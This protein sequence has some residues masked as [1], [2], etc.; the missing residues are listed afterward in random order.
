MAR[1][2]T[3]DTVHHLV[4]FQQTGNTASF[5]A[6]WADAEAFVDRNA[7]TW[8]RSHV[9]VGADGSVDR[10]AVDDVKQGF[11]IK[12]LELPKKANQSG[13]FD[14]DRFGWEPDRLRGWIYRVV[15]NVAVDYCKQF[16]NLGK[17]TASITFGD[18]ELNDGETVESVL[19]PSPKVDFDAF[20]LRDI[21][22]ECL[23]EL[24]AEQRALCHEFFV[25]GLS[26]R[27]VARGTGVSAPTVCRHWQE[28]A[29]VLR[30]KLL[31]RGVDASWLNH[32]A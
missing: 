14:H 17:K 3:H 10:T 20:E 31:A 18:L 11:V 2:I 27:D 12:I 28:A 21:V 32:A 22:A 29:D 5:E 23:G 7:S 30:A 6:F 13:W 1:S 8:L 15:R 4:T 24:T 16:H 26:Q 19:K 25:K 9:V